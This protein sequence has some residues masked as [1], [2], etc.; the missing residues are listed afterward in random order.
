MNIVIPACDGSDRYLVEVDPEEMDGPDVLYIV[1][2]YE[3]VEPR[4]RLTRRGARRGR[5]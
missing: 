1:E 5:P 4:S 3:Y 2:P